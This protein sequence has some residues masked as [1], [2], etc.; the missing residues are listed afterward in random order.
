[1]A[2]WLAL[3]FDFNCM[4]SDDNSLLVYFDLSMQHVLNNDAS[5][6]SCLLHFIGKP[7]YTKFSTQHEAL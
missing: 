5:D 1:M 2:T 3:V 4:Q 7:A 6:S